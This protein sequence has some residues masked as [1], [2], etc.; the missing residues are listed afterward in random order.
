MVR[1]IRDTR[2]PF[3]VDPS[4]RRTPQKTLLRSKRTRLPGGD[5]QVGRAKSVLPLGPCVKAKGPRCCACFSRD[6]RDGGRQSCW[7]QARERPQ[8]NDRSVPGR[9]CRRRSKVPTAISKLTSTSVSPVYSTTSFPGREAG[10]NALA[11]RAQAK[12]S[13]EA[14]EETPLTFSRHILE[15]FFL[16]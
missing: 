3:T 11:S 15:Q 7:P 6:L 8:A 5:L 16:E 9:R 13:E 12:R 14:W 2:S 1:D 10:A 4:V